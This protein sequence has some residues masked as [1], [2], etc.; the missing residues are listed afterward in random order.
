MQFCQSSEWGVTCPRRLLWYCGG[1]TL[2]SCVVAL[3]SL[4][5]TNVLQVLLIFLSMTLGYI[6]LCPPEGALCPVQSQ[7]CSLP[8]VEPNTEL[9]QIFLHDQ[10]VIPIYVPSLQRLS[11]DGLHTYRPAEVNESPVS[12]SPF[13]PVQLFVLAHPKSLSKGT[14]TDL[15]ACASVCSCT[16]LSEPASYNRISCNDKRVPLRGDLLLLKSR[17][18]ALSLNTSIKTNSGVNPVHISR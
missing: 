11:P 8:K 7:F 16:S 6:C 17:S 18:K 13:H 15:S 3:W 1:I 4:S 12:P 14:Q 5:P 9:V 2:L 10:S